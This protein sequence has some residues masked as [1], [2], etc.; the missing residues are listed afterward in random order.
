MSKRILTEQEELNLIEYYQSHSDDNTARTFH[1]HFDPTII[2]LLDK[3]NVKRHTKEENKALRAILFS[4]A[5]RKK[6]DPDTEQQII[7]YYSEHSSKATATKF[8]TKAYIIDRIIQRHGIETHTK[9]DNVKLGVQKGKK[10]CLKHFG[11]DSPLK[12]KDVLNR[13]QQTNIKRYGNICSAQGEEI[14]SKIKQTMIAKYGTENAFESDICKEKTKQTMIERYGVDHAHMCK[15]VYIFNEERFDSFPELCFYMYHVKN[16]IEIER[17][18]KPLEYIINGEMHK[19]YP[20]FKVNDKLVE[21]KGDQFLNDNG[22]WYN[23]YD[24]TTSYLYEA[25]Y[26]CAVENSVTILYSADY[27]KYLDWFKKS[28][29]NKDDFKI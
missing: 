15:A 22:V 16:S 6:F 3:Y 12:N 25:K 11:V 10:T 8:H 23:P 1:C 26:H 14:A 5:T 28:G 18:P 24:K 7:S 20:D 27:Q 2:R 19:Y 13:L 21:L 4:Q 9:E 29:Y 17:N